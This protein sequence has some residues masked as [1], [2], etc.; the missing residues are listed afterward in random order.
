MRALLLVL[1][2]LLSLPS[3]AQ[4]DYTP[5]YPAQFKILSWNIHMLPY[6]VYYKTK[7][8]KRCNGI[9]EELGKRDYNIIVFQEAFKMRARH[10][11]YKGL[12]EKYPY[13]YGPANR[14]FSW[15]TNS[16]IWVLSDR[17][18]SVKGE[19]EFTECAN[20]GCLARK[21]GLL[22]EGEH[23]GHIFQIVGT[24]TNGNPQEVNRHQF[25][26][27][28]DELLKPNEDSATIQI[29]CGDMNCQKSKPEDYEAM[30]RLLHVE[31]QLHYNCKEDTA[32]TTEIDQTVDYILVRN[33]GA[34]I[35]I[36]RT[37]T[38]RIGPA[39]KS[40]NPKRY[41]TTV[42]LSDHYSVEMIL[43]WED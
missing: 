17:P 9:V 4:Q 31:Q 41:G 27:L 2:L 13:Q 37:A 20:D 33:N 8:G 12:K 26:Q 1:A 3:F 32:S 6:C 30:L 38:I 5:P 39:W 24:H 36:K 10:K 43:E 25:R 21:G 22:V 15:K 23:N 35:T 42:G 11:I 14:K 29:I 28:Y 40:G 18:L 34:N 19:V 7:K 16:G